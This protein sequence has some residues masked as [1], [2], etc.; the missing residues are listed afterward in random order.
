MVQ[1]VRFGR[2]TFWHDCSNAD[3]V[4]G[5]LVSRLRKQTFLEETIHRISCNLVIGLTEASRSGPYSVADFPAAPNQLSSFSF[6]KRSFVEK[7]M[8]RP[9]LSS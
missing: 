4:K 7:K 5:N 8:N 6:P 2:T 9:F 1:S 3:L